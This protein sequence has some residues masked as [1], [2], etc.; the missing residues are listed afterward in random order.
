MLVVSSGR[1]HASLVTRTGIT[2][3]CPPATL[4][5]NKSD[6]LAKARPSGSLTQDLPNGLVLKRLL[7]YF[8]DNPH[9]S[10]SYSFTGGRELLGLRPSILGRQ[11]WIQ[12]RALGQTA[13]SV[14]LMLPR[15]RHAPLRS[16]FHLS[17]GVLSTYLRDVLSF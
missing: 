8:Q 10:P 14:R 15:V 1:P 11:G 7:D 2:P 5:I 4:R 12:P 6:C 9:T 3:S 17:K 16:L 13:L